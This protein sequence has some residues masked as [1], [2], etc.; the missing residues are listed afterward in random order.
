MAVVAECYVKGVSTRRVDG[1]VKTL[2]I[3]GISK[4]QVSELARSLGE[5]VAAFRSRPLDAGPY[6]YVWLDAL[7]LKCREGGRI[8][9]V[10]AVVATRV[11]ADGY[12]EILGLDVLTSEDGAGWTAFLRDLVA[13]GLTGVRLAI[14]DDHQGLV[15]AIAAGDAT[16]VENT[17]AGHE[18]LVGWLSER[19]PM[20]RCGMELSGGI[21]RGLAVALVAAGYRVVVVPP[22]LSH[23]EADR[24]RSRGKADPSDALAVA[25]VTLRE[26]DLPMVRTGDASED[27]KLL[28]DHRDQLWNERT[29]VAN[30]LHADLSIAYPGY[31]RTIG[32]AL[33]SR[34]SLV[35]A[36]SLLATDTSVRAELARRRI[37]RMRELHEE[38][39]DIERRLAALVDARPTT[40]TAIVGISTI[41]AARIIGEVGDVRRFPTPSAFAS[42]NGTAPVSASSGRTHRH[43]LN[44]G[45]NRRLNRALY[46]VALTQTRHEPRAVAYLERKRAEGKTRREAMRCLKRRL[47][48][49]VYGQLM[50][51]ARA[52]FDTTPGPHLTHRS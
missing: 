30:R 48:D 13:R 41:T 9:N 45:G 22:R 16:A 1:L 40:L 15:E 2:G 32:R 38:L 19:A 4:S 51:D 43:R 36:E 28:V 14:S 42:A 12:R 46:V 39:R 50:A 49:V 18:A 35:R 47:S 34:A 25:R 11:N 10:S 52:A 26:P 29:R 3:E 6:T 17:A 23:R 20:A 44:R 24:L 31:Q 37:S 5:A 8:A 7:V 27:L 21:A 33:T